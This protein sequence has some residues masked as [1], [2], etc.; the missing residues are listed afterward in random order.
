MKR[1]ILLVSLALGLTLMSCSGGG[2]GGGTSSSPAQT[3][4]PPPPPPPPPPVSD[5]NVT[6]SGSVTFDRVP[7]SQPT[8]ELDFNSIRRDPARGIMLELQDAGGTILA[9]TLTDSN[10]N[11][12]F[13]APENTD[14]R[15]R[16]LSALNEVGGVTFDFRVLDNANS[17]AIY[18]LSGG[19]QSSG[20][21]TQTRNLNAPSGWNGVQYASTRA[22]APFAILDSVYEATNLIVETDP[23]VTLE[24]LS[25]FWSVDNFPSDEGGIG[26]GTFFTRVDGVN[27]VSLLGGEDVDTDE[28]D[29][30]LVVHEFAHFLERELFRGNSIG[31]P[32]R[33]TDRLDKRVAF[34]EGFATAFSGM[35][36]SDR[37][38]R[39]SF[40][41]GQQNT[42][43][44]DNEF[45][46]VFQNGWYNETTIL[47]ML[48]DIFDNNPDGADQLA[49]GFEPIYTA[50]RSPTFQNMSELTSIFGFLEALAEQPGMNIAALEALM[51]QD[52]INSRESD[53]AGETND[54]NIQ[55]S[56]PVYHTLT[57]GGP[58]IEVCSV[59]PAGTQNKLGNY[60]FLQFTLPGTQSI[61][62]EASV[63]PGSVGVSDPD[64]RLWRRGGLFVISD[65]PADGSESFT[66]TLSSG[67]Y[68]IEIFD[69]GNREED[70]DGTNF[71]FDVSVR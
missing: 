37:V 38:Y 56:L 46:R 63:A 28:F 53:G 66:R 35:V 11:Y 12:S 30:H 5:G 21:G 1:S 15:V 20:T 59:N 13:E 69:F 47:N 51:A 41:V 18:V 70:S 39:D 44:I 67:T 16:A 17:D 24:P 7:F 62:V 25:I 32:H 52:G 64:L 40:G 54:G 65:S 34:S 71:C 58:A 29:T 42:L 3:I 10:G 68:V 23:A 14:V 49:L 19:L 61:T 2:G 26:T 4:D 6:I 55:T 8:D 27:Q 33:L 60:S 45:S 36:F 43:V 50:L 31:G 22:A 57:V 48:Y 9:T